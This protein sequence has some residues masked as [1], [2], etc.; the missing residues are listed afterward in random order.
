MRGA[1]GTV[2]VL[3]A[4]SQ[5]GH[6]LLP[7]LRRSGIDVVAASRSAAAAEADAVRWVRLDPERGFGTEHLPRPIDAVV[8]LAPLHVLP[9][10]VDGLA[11]IGAR[12]I[13]AF[14]STSVIKATSADPKE[15]RL[16][17]GLR[18]GEADLAQVCERHGID[19]TVFRPTLVYSSGLDRNVSEIARFIRRFRVFPIVGAGSGL[20]QPV[21][22]ADLAAACLGALQS[23]TA[24]NKSY[25]LS[26]GRTLT[27]REMVEEVF[28]ALGMRPRFVRVPLWLIKA[29]IRAA[30]FL[31]RFAKL[32]P[33]LATRMNQ[34]LCFDSTPAQH[35]FGFSPRAFSLQELAG[36]TASG[37]ARM[38][39]PQPRP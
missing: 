7:L 17:V 6:Y 2:L 30:A 23:S 8:S 22:A 14:G 13:I 28:R 16:A 3:G 4:R 31:P 32:S 33:E 20:R 27:Y 19:W 11:A 10:L 29:G 39:Q 36:L 25:D 9:P 37:Q 34:D 24:C 12:R 18:E 5:I 26:G 1:G 35:D 21:H 15:R 38:R